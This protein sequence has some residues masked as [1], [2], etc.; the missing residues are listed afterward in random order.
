MSLKLNTTESLTPRE[1]AELDWEKETTR[2]QV[3]LHERQQDYEL[4]IKLLEVK[5]TQLFKLPHLIILLPIKFIMA[6]A[7]PISVITKKELPPAFWE[8]MHV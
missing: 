7:I 2:L 3:Q 1:R 5:W 6:F 8:F 4:K